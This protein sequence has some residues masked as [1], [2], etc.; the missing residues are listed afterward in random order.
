[1]MKILNNCR[2]MSIDRYL[3]ANL[4]ISKVGII[5]INNECGVLKES[6]GLY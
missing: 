2:I 4:N 1:M 3:F 5:L 6:R